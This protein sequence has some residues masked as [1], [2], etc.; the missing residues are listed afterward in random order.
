[1][2]LVVSI[3]YSLPMT[4]FACIT[5]TRE[6]LNAMKHNMSSAFYKDGSLCIA[7]TV[8]QVSVVAHGLLF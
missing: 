4:R 6:Y 8:F 3:T 5:D 1:M 2:I 7:R